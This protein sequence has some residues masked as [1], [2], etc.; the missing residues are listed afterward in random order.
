MNSSYTPTPGG[1]PGRGLTIAAFVCAI[2]GIFSYGIFSV[3]GLVLAYVAR[4]QM[5]RA[6]MM[7]DGL[8]RW[9]MWISA[10]SLILGV[11]NW[12]LWGCT[13]LPFMGGGYYW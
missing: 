12:F 2:L 3:I 6:G 11:L 5:Q 9:A 4:G 8:N 10:G 7:P 13:I 1:Y